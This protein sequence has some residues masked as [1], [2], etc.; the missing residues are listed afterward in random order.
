VQFPPEL[1]PVMNIL[2]KSLVGRTALAGLAL[3]TVLGTASRGAAITNWVIDQG[4]PITMGLDTSSPTIGDNS[5]DNADMVIFHAVFPTI[6]LTNHGDAIRLTGSVT[7]FGITSS[8]TGT[9]QQL[10]FGLFDNLGAPG[11]NGWLGYFVANST[12]VNAGVIRQR[13]AGNPDLFISNTGST[14]VASTT[15]PPNSKSGG[16]I[17][18]DTYNFLLQITRDGNNFDISGSLSGGPGGNFFDSFTINDLLPA[19]TET[20]IFNSAGFLLGNAM[21]V[22]Q[23]QYNNI[24]V[25]FV[26]EPSSCALLVFGSVLFAHRRRPP[27][28]G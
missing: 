2:M 26:P 7:L 8:D 25:I 12:A 24:E 9:N 22:D 15:N 10:R 3:T 28:L 19:A 27:V 17:A 23:A 16:I 21:N 14:I 18:N 5:P 11:V 6:T 4:T 1:T 13:N 20:Y